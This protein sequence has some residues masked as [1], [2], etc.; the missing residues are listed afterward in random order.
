LWLSLTCSYC[1]ATPAV[2]V[3]AAGC[4]KEMNVTLGFRAVFQAKPGQDLVLKIVASS[5]YRASLNGE[6]LGSGPARAAHSYFRV[7]EY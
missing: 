5:I 1:H 3:W 7:D 4:E 2:P 6:F